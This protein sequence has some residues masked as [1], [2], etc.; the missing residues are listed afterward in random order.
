MG[1]VLSVISRVTDKLP[2]DIGHPVQFDTTKSNWYIL[3]STTTTTNKI[4]EGIVGF[5]TEIEANNSATY[6]QR[7]SESRALDDRIYR[8]RYVIPKEFSATIA[9]KPEKNYTLQESR[10]VN[11][12]RVL[13]SSNA[14]TNRNPKIISGISSTGTTVTVTS[15]LPHKLSVN[16]VV[17][18][19]NVTSS[20]NTGAL[21][22]VGFNGTFT[23]TGTPSPKSFTYSNSNLGGTF[24][25]NLGTLRADDILRPNLPAFERKEYDTT[26]T[27]QEVETIQDYISGEQD[28][29][30]YLTCLIGNISPTVSEFSDVRYRQTS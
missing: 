24:T 4:H 23:V 12:E 29:V 15:D 22:N 3:S 18:V 17:R 5:S 7:I 13:S 26:Y 25:N 19:K 10:T 9:K 1:G 21:D 14:I 16:D 30:Y 27:I 8:L 2:G 11:E 6:V 20:A 28:G